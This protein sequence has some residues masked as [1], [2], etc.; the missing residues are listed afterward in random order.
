MLLC[1]IIFSVVAVPL[2]VL[3]LTFQKLVISPVVKSYL[4][5]SQFLSFVSVSTKVKII[6]GVYKKKKQTQFF[7]EKVVALTK[8]PLESRKGVSG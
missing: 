4:S 6:L 3:I 2:K 8:Q 7:L 1:L 5:K